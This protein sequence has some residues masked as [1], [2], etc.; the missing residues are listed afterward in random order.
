MANE[1]DDHEKRTE[2]HRAAGLDTSEY[3]KPGSNTDMHP[4][5]E[6]MAP[7]KMYMKST[8]KLQRIMK[9]V[10]P[11]I[12][13]VDSIETVPSTDKVKRNPKT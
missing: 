12:K 11:L 10:T 13:P 1:H 2:A 9:T 3:K 6:D 4:N 5:R 7:P 8:E